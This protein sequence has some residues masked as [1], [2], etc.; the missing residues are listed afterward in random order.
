MLEMNRMPALS[1]QKMP[2]NFVPGKTGR[3]EE[4]RK[5]YQPD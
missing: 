2:A 4:T 3:R 1:S 5:I